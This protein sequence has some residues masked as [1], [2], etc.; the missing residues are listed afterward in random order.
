VIQV[1]MRCHCG[2]HATV[3]VSSTP[4]RGAGWCCLCTDCYD[5]TPVSDEQGPGARSTCLGYGATP[6]EAIA[7]WWEQVELAWDID[8]LPNTLLAEL[9]EQVGDEA[10]RQRGWVKVFSRAREHASMPLAS[11]P[12][13]YLPYGGRVQ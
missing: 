5:D 10:E 13:W 9:S 6:E 8:Y 7:A 2:T 1:A 11:R 3:E 12:V 4:S